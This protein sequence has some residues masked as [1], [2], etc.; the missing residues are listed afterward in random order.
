V[1]APG[2]AA[3]ADLSRAEIPTIVLEA[4]NRIGGRI[5]TI[6]DSAYG[7]PVE[8]GAEFIHGNPAA[9]WDVIREAGLVAHDVTFNQWERRGKRLL[10]VDESSDELDKVM[11]GLTRVKRHDISFAEYLRRF[12]SG[13]PLAHARLMATAFV[14]RFDAA[15]PERIS[16]KSLAKEQE[17]LADF[18]EAK[19]F[20]LR[21]GYASLTNQLSEGL[22][23]KF[24]KVRLNSI[25][26]EI[27]WKSGKVEIRL[28]DRSI[29]QAKA[30][31]I[32]LPLGVLQLPAEAA[33]AVRFIPDLIGKGLEA[34]RLGYGPVVK[35]ILSFHEPFWEDAR[36]ARRAGAH[37]KLNDAV[38]L[39]DPDAP[40][41]T[42]WTM[43]P[44]R[45]PVLTTWAGGPKAQALSECKEPELIEAALESVR[46]IFG[47][48]NR[49]LTSLLSK[50]HAYNW[51]ADPFSQGA[52]SYELVN[53]ASARA[54]LAKPI[55][56][57]LFF[58][59]EATDTSGEASTVAGAIASG[60]RAAKEIL[61]A[62]YTSD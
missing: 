34:M 25:V 50:A 54:R 39:F 9:T 56:K 60:H 30:A 31:L 12:C 29:V 40:F 58:A 10:H 14:E 44:L 2:L 20:R 18:D 22:D 43:L 11:A 13:R 53:G 32:T 61:A 49:W 7:M 57:T 1:Q 5:H 6:C 17:G 51:Q 62:I 16:A 27:R 19:Q 23:Q 3:A 33:G 21:D 47:M 48:Q 59:G 37:G 15:D 38:F 36:I 52:Y 8:L 45:L 46:R 42:I 41:P 28:A 4:R 55:G 35:A 26:S 24:V